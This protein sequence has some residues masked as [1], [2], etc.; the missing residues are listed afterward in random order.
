MS[1]HGPSNVA[2][3]TG[4]T[5]GIGLGLARELAG[6]GCNV[7]VCGRGADGVEAAVAEVAAL[8]SPSQVTGTTCDVTDGASIQALWDHA[9]ATFGRVDIWIN[10]AG[11]TT[12]PVPLPDVPDGQIEKVVQTNLVGLMLGCKIAATGMRNQD[13]GGGF[14]YNVEGMGSKGETQNGMATYGATKAATGYLMKALGKELA[15]TDVKICAIRPGINVTKHLVTDVHVLDPERWRKSKKILNIL[16]DLPETTTP[17]LAEQ[18]LKND[19]GGTRIQWLTTSKVIMRF[20][21]AGKY[22]KRD[23]FAQAGFEDPFD[24][25]RGTAST[26]AT[27][28]A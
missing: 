8:T 6:R 1:S 12:T 10:N 2:V 19:K 18:I 5:R 17:W 9:V 25:D 13:S 15:D 14:I 26:D 20:M 11:S 22:G 4:S 7:V 23:L 24:T 16:G 28:S 3:I 27:A 21:L